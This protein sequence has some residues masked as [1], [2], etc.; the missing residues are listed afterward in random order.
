MVKNAVFRPRG[1]LQKALVTSKNSQEENI[2][3]ILNL[4]KKRLLFSSWLK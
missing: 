3:I 2:N 4:K 1:K